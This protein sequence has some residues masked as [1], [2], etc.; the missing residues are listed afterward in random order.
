[1]QGFVKLL[2]E[3]QKQHKISGEEFRENRAAWQQLKPN[4]REVLVLRLKQRLNTENKSDEAPKSQPFQKPR[5][6]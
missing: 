1:M 2:G 6:L 4:D 5:R 3:L